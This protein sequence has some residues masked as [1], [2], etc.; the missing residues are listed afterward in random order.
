M[1][2]VEDCWSCYSNS[3]SQGIDLELA[4]CQMRLKFEIYQRPAFFSLLT[5]DKVQPVVSQV[6]PLDTCIQLCLFTTLRARVSFRTDLSLVVDSTLGGLA[7]RHI[8]ILDNNTI[9]VLRS[10]SDPSSLGSSAASKLEEVVD[11]SGGRL[12]GA[13]VV[14][15]DLKLECT[16]TSVH[17]SGSKP[18]LRRTSVHLDLKT[19]GD[20][21]GNKLPLDG[22]FAKVLVGK[23]REHI[24]RH[25][26]VVLVTAGL[27]SNLDRESVCACV[28]YNFDVHTMAIFLTPL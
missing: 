22:N 1:N 17:D 27:V 8:N 15:T 12:P 13:T 28:L 21:A 25:V 23:L 5:I 16:Q 9:T 18:V 4:S 11:V 10:S 7:R 2:M 14:G 19:I 26:Q 24:G 6:I 3:A 20:G